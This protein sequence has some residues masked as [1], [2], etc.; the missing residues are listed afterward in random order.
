VTPK[1]CLA[2][3]ACALW[4]LAGAGCSD[5]HLVTGVYRSQQAVVL[6]D[7]PGFAGDGLFVEIVLGQYGPD[8]T[9]LVRFYRDANFLFAAPGGC[10]CRFVQ[11]GR[12]DDGVV[13]LAFPG[14]VPCDDSAMLVGARLQADETGDRLEG[15]LGTALDAGPAWAFDRVVPEAEM[16]D[17]HKACEEQLVVEAR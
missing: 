16:T 6:D 17:G 12:Y 13:L 8:V 9:G 10:D 3:G 11:E 2:F 14:P 7:I 5:A 4:L 1:R 15:R